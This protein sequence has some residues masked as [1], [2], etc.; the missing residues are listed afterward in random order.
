[1]E[2][3]K[4]IVVA[5]VQALL[6]ACYN[7][8]EWLSTKDGYIAKGILFI[9]FLYLSYLIAFN[10]LKIKKRAILLSSISLIIYAIGYEIFGILRSIY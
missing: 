3:Y 10:I 6:W 4:W 9:F 5:C 8:I 7:I 2:K 1:M